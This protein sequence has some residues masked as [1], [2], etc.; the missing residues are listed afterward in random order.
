MVY[1][2]MLPNAVQQ[3]TGFGVSFQWDISMLEGYSWKALDNA[4][5]KPDLGRFLGSSTPTIF[6][7]LK[8]DRPDMV[9]IGGWNALPLLQALRACKQLMIPRMVRGDS[10]ALRPRPAGVR[11]L[12]RVLLNQF[13]GFLAVGKANKAFYLANGVKED[14]I[15]AVP[16]FVDNARF[17]SCCE[18]LLPA[19]GKSRLKWGIADDA[20]CFLFAGKIEPKKRILDLVA[21]MAGARN[22]P[23]P[24]HLLVAG[25]GVMMDEAKALALCEHVSA[26]FVGFLNQSELPGAYA[27]AD[28]LVLPSDYGETW[29]LVVNEAMACG[30]PAVVSDRV[31]CGPDLVEHGLTGMRFPFGDVGALARTL[32]FLSENGAILRKMGEQ[33]RI[34]VADYSI[35]RAVEGT[36]RAVRSVLGR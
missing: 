29:G 13:D 27:A 33:A 10:N 20:I 4:R 15:F 1:Y 24:L 31:G 19:R 16:H 35:E 11:L 3:G 14:R 32:Q 6:D 26:T 5:S 17:R 7:V 34:R 8:H 25:S 18:R 2:A 9:I 21:A 28:C 36:V 23:H 12:H 30:L 22:A